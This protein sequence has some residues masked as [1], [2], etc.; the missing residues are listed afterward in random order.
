MG[1]AGGDGAASRAVQADV[2]FL[3]N[4]WRYQLSI[5]VPALPGG[6]WGA[7]PAWGAGPAWGT[8]PDSQASTAITPPNETASMKNTAV[9]PLAAMMIPA[10]P[11]PAILASPVTVANSEVPRRSS[12]PADQ[13]EHEGL[14]GHRW[15]A[16]RPPAGPG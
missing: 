12:V 7:E 13:V 11:G 1:A 2:P 3:P 14:A 8:W 16:T 4:E 5:L 15:P 9:S 6:V 10:T